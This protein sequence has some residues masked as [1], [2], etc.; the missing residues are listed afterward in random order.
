[1]VALVVI[2]F[3]PRRR[4]G[5][6]RA[7]RNGQP[8]VP[9][10]GIGGFD[11]RRGLEGHVNVLRPVGHPHRDHDRSDQRNLIDHAADG[12]RGNAARTVDHVDDAA[13]ALPAEH[14]V[15]A[16]WRGDLD[17]QWA[18]K[19]PHHI[20]EEATQRGI[21]VLAKLVEH[22]AGDVC[23]CALTDAMERCRRV[24]Q[25]LLI[26]KRRGSKRGEL[27]GR[28]GFNQS[29]YGARDGAARRQP[30]RN[31]WPSRR[32]GRGRRPNGA[33]NRSNAFA[34]EPVAYR[35]SRRTPSVHRPSS[36]T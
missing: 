3:R 7:A 5:Y 14:Y 8:P 13:R 31:R 33:P 15:H 16:T 27:F 28:C 34:P 1:M 32:A 21:A 17:V 12:C 24:G 10:G 19:P 29:P 9:V 35:R 6:E 22:V 18:G 20:V 23:D 25:K 36:R 4:H 2:P 26:E 11:R 30:G